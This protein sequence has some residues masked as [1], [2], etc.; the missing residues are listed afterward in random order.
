[1]VSCD[2]TGD[3]RRDNRRGDG[4]VGFQSRHNGAVH[5][6]SLCGYAALHGFAIGSP[7]R[8]ASIGSRQRLGESAETGEDMA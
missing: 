2:G 7:V 8:D 5:M 3:N 4:R 6:V 1:M